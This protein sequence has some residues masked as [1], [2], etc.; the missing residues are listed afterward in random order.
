M[1]WNILLVMEIDVLVMEMSWNKFSN[2]VYEPYTS[3]IPHVVRYI[4]ISL[5]FSILV[6]NG[7]QINSDIQYLVYATMPIKSSDWAHD[8]KTFLKTQT[9]ACWVVDTEHMLGINQS[10]W[11]TLGQI[12]NNFFVA[13]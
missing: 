9:Q 11:L 6:D 2:L 5:P 3:K 8:Y 10:A 7:Q 1:F 4:I 12:N 13:T